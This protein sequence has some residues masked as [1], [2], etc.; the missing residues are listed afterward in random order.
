MMTL[1]IPINRIKRP[2]LCILLPVTV[3]LVLVFSTIAILH[4]SADKQVEGTS[5]SANQSRRAFLTSFGW[6]VSQEPIEI[7]Q[8]LIPGEFDRV[9]TTYNE[10]Q[11][12]QGYDLLKYKGLAVTRYTYEVLNYNTTVKGPIHANLLI[13]KNKIIGGDICSLDLYGF[14]HGFGD[15]EV[16]AGQLGEE[17]ESRDT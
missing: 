10:V 5:N 15:A 16:S 12:H 3:V 17:P 13:Y 14:I 8:V 7:K 11:K 2:F 9:Y 6:K 1:S 4:A